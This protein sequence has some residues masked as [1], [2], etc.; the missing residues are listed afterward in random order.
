MK[1]R[2]SIIAIL[3]FVLL[4][5]LSMV[6]GQVDASLK[7]YVRI[8]SLQS[9][10]SAYGSERGWNNSYYE[11]MIWPA[12]YRFQ[13][14]AVIKRAWAASR[15]FKDKNGAFW[16]RYGV[17]YTQDAEGIGLF[18]MELTQTSR[19]QPPNVY[20]DGNDLGVIFAGEIDAIDPD[21]LADRI[22]TN[23]VNSSMGLTMTRKIYAFSQQYHDNYFIKEFTFTNTGNADWD[24]DIELTDSL[25]GVRIG[26]GTRYSM[27][28][29]ANWTIGDGQSWGKH[30]WVTRRG[31]DYSLH[32]QEAITPD[33]PIVDWLRA[34]FSWAGQGE[35]N[36]FDNIGGPDLTA[37]GRLT[38]P[39][40]T[41][42][43][44]LH[45]DR[46]ALDPEDWIAQPVFLGW[47]AGDTYPKIGDQRIEN[48]DAMSDLYEMLSG[49]PFG[50]SNMGDTTRMDEVFTGGDIT[51]PFDPWKAHNDGGGTNVMMT[52]G[53]FDLALG[54][55]IHIVEAEGINGLSREMCRVIGERW[56]QAYNTP[57]DN[58]PFTLPDGNETTDMNVF[59]NSWVYTGKDSIMLTFG[60]AK[61]NYDS[62]FTIPQPPQPPQSFTVES[63]GDLIYTSWLPSLSE[64]DAD[65]GGYRLFRAIG[66]L[67]TTFEE[68]FACGFG[69]DNPELSYYYDDISPVRGQNYFYYLVAFNDG[70][71]N[72]TTLNPSGS[73]HSNRFYTRT[74][75]A[76]TLK[77]KAG[78]LEKVRI[79]PNPYNINQE[80]FLGQ[81]DKLAFY[82]IPGVCTIR[83]YTER[84]D[85]IKTI[86]HTDGSGD[87]FWLLSTDALQVISSGIYIAHFEQPDG[88]SILEKFI[89]IR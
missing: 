68:I 74:T 70:S 73:L 18:P 39:H 64:N 21:Q 82:D 13:D 17:Y 23:I 83:I 78:N 31:E 37:T 7:R 67:D 22:I 51:D 26:W 69:T 14:N 57:G 76:A 48:V 80:A 79:V 42:S 46:S 58:G 54:E 11:G 4:L 47:H 89:V 40:H 5:G 34:G 35:K 62:G 1:I 75:Q 72:N 27:G 86:Q 65:F 15:D 44:V 87:E 33:N 28:R 38:S 2:R 49:H 30:T 43:V 16:S 61:R 41:G 45:V 85:L 52:Y 25:L 60:R 20:V 19:F 9:Q 81:P 29:E 63:G 6:Q 84:G 50:G 8:G 66:E 53:P 3:S 32:Y 12:D 55:S 36:T 24:A 71:E 10:F 59:K 88:R 56:Q 77:R